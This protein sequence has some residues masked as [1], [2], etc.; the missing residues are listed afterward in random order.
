MTTKTMHINSLFQ[1]RENVKPTLT[2]RQQEVLN[3][4]EYGGGFTDEDVAEKLGYPI[5]RISGRVGELIKLGKIRELKKEETKIRG[6]RVC[7]IN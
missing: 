5:N 7:V 6:R 3:V 1:W 2:K 4:Y